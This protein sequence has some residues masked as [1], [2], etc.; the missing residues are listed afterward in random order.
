MVAKIMAVGDTREDARQR[1]MLALQG[2]ALFGVGNNRDF[3][4]DVLGKQEFIDGA[5]TTAFIGDH[6]GDAFS[7]VEP[8]TQVLA[9]AAVVQHGIAQA[10]LQARALSVS[11]E[12]LD[13]SSSADLAFSRGYLVGDDVV[14]VQLQAQGDGCYLVSVG[15]AEHSVTLVS[16]EGAQVVLEI[17]GMRVRSVSRTRARRRFISPQIPA[18]FRWS[19][20]SSCRLTALRLPVVVQSLPPCMGCCS[21]LMLPPVMRW[22]RGSVSGC[23]RP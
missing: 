15:E 13:W 11:D 6:Y 18:V 20:S 9:A 23:S 2:S 21:V 8:S 7:A 4:I 14:V 1:L 19:T 10:E 5:A 12:L 17:D 3:L 22:S 16:V